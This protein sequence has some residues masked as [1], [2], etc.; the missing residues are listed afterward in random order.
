MAC[1]DAQP[2][3]PLRVPQAAA[4]EKNLIRVKGQ[5][6]S[7]LEDKITLELVQ[8]LIWLFTFNF[9]AHYPAK[10]FFNTAIH[11]FDHILLRLLLLQVSLTVQILRL[12]VA[13][14]LGQGGFEEDEVGWEVLILANLYNTANLKLMAAH[15]M[16]RFLTSE[17]SLALSLILCG[18]LLFALIVLHT[19]LDH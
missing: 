19:V 14:A 16:H 2:K 4:L 1:E 9:C 15:G 18:I 6:L 3:H 17:G 10:R 11:L 13:E 5:P 7:I 12:H 8:I